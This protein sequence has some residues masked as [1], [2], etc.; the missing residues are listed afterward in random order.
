MKDTQDGGRI[1]FLLLGTAIGAI[2][3]LMV[4]P[5]S[6]ARTRRTLRR[7]GEDVADYVID[8]V[9]AGKELADRCEHLYKRSGQLVGE[10]AHE[11]SDKYRDLYQRSKNLV[12]EA[13]CMIRGTGK[14]A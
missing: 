14:T 10:A 6:G 7:K 3:A 4:A 8:I 1:T 2:A 9:D 12:D 11:L 13:A 5:A